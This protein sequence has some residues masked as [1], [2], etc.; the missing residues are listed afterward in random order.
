MLAK[1][2]ICVK[3]VTFLFKSPQFPVVLLLSQGFYRVLRSFFKE[4]IGNARTR[5]QNSL[6][7]AWVEVTYPE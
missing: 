4:L 5:V 3:I 1:T 2:S 7:C 6:A